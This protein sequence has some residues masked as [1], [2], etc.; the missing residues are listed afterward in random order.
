M[1]WYLLS[2]LLA[3]ILGACS[4]SEPMYNNAPLIQAQSDY[5]EYRI[6]EDWYKGYWSIA[7]Q[8]AHDT[9]QVICY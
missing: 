6:G 4:S 9:L 5:T 1:R 2:V 7:P 3:F 8:V